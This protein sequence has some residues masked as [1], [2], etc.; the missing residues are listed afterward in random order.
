MKFPYQKSK[1]S[2]VDYTSGDSAAALMSSTTDGKEPCRSV[3]AGEDAPLKK[4]ALFEKVFRENKGAM[5]ILAGGPDTETLEFQIWA[6][7]EKLVIV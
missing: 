1:L 3:K 2:V 4:H 6:A 5:D 7:K